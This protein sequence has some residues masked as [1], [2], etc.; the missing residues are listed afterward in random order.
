[1]VHVQPIDELLFGALALVLYEM[2]YLSTHHISHYIV[3]NKQ[4]NG[5]F[6]TVIVSNK[7]IPDPQETAWFKWKPSYNGCIHLVDIWI[8]LSDTIVQISFTK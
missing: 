3:W 1:M 4:L 8:S 7:W 5:S 6:I 2:S